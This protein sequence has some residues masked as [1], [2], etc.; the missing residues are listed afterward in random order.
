MRRSD[1]RN[2]IYE[3][4]VGQSRRLMDHGERMKPYARA[5]STLIWEAIVLPLFYGRYHL[6]LNPWVKRY[7]F[8]PGRLLVL[9]GR[10]HRAALRWEGVLR[11]RGA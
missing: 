4:Q 11:E 10:G 1:W 9:E 2:E 3:R 5:H 8:S 7:P 6:M